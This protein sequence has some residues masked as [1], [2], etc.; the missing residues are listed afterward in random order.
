MST[1][2]NPLVDKVRAMHPGAYDDLS[3]AE[4]TSKLVAK[5]PQYGDLAQPYDKTNQNLKMQ[6]SAAPDIVRGITGTLPAAG[7]LTAGLASSPSVVG[8]AAGAALGA[9]GGEQARLLANRAIFG[10]SE[11]S[12]ISKEGLKGTAEQGA[13]AG[14]TAGIT[15]GAGKLLFKPAPPP[16]LNPQE[17]NSAIGATM[18]S[19]RIG[20]GATD[21]MDASTMPAR[22]LIK[23][24]F[25][26]DTLKEMTPPEQMAAIAPYW[27]Q[28]GQAVDKAIGDATQSGATVDVGKSAFQTFSKIKNPELQDKMIDQFNNLAREIGIG[29]QRAATPAEA[30]QLR[31]ALQA[32]ARFSPMGDLN[33]LGGVRAQLYGSVS[34]DLHDAVPGLADIDQHYSD[35][36]SAMDAVQRGAIKYAIKAPPEPDP[37][38]LQRVGNAAV[39]KYLPAAAAGAVGA[40][41]GV[42]VHEL[43]K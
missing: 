39:K 35:L 43:L 28:A 16:N 40:G 3:D 19:V 15:E 4:L 33:S 9:A 18:K 38:L 34:G 42:L 23:V 17:I 13:I 32:G 25:N 14:A 2:L 37:S 30:R 36:R 21:L 6:T 5:F 26:A 31:Q 10:P 24:G 27:K 22:G 8:T 1:G 29:N 41:G 11:T 12:P 7:A 20:K